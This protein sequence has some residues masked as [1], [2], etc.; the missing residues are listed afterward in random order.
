MRDTLTQAHFHG[1]ALFVF[2]V[3]PVSKVEEFCC[4]VLLVDVG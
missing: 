3:Q 1:A 4:G 2:C